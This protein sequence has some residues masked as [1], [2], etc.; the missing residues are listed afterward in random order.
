MSKEIESKVSVLYNSF[1]LKEPNI[2]TYM[3][4]EVSEMDENM[5]G[6]YD[7]IDDLMDALNN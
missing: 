2:V 1:K 6:P 7:N 3:A 4:M 5:Y